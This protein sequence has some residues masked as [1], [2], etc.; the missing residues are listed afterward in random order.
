MTGRRTGS[1]TG[2]RAPEPEDTASDPG[3]DGSAMN[4]RQSQPEIHGSLVS[5]GRPPS[6]LQYKLT[7][8]R[9]ILVVLAAGIAALFLASCK[10]SPPANV[11]AEVNGHASEEHTS[12]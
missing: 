6:W 9:R 8:M 1:G 4:F 5:R 2:D 7:P 11:A 12:E 10:H 3:T